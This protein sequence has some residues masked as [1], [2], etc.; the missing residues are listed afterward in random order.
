M[1]SV[2]SSIHNHRLTGGHLIGLGVTDATMYLNSG[3]TVPPSSG[4]GYVNAQ[5]SVFNY[6]TATNARA[7]AAV[8]LDDTSAVT[9][10][11]GMLLEDMGDRL[12]FSALGQTVLIF[13]KVR[14]LSNLSTEGDETQYW[15]CIWAAAPGVF[16]T[17]KLQ[18]I[19]GVARL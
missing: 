1:S 5:G 13:A 16:D 18:A 2:H 15:H 6:S 17:D 19:V 11:A 8:A 3:Y 4:T 14:D 12:V 7:A 9:V 10:T